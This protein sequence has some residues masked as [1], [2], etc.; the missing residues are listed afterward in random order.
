VNNAQEPK[1]AVLVLLEGGLQF[2][3]QN[4]K[5][6]AIEQW[7]QVLALEPDNRLAKEYLEAA[8]AWGIEAPGAPPLR[9]VR[10]DDPTPSK[11]VDASTRESVLSLVKAHRFEDALTVLYEAHRKAPADAAVSRSIAV[12]KQRVLSDYQRELGSL[13]QVPFVQ[14]QGEHLKRVPLSPN[15]QELVGLVDGLVTFGDILQSSQRGEL[16]STKALV[17]LLRKGV[18]Q[19]KNQSTALLTKIQTQELTIEPPP[20]MSPSSVFPQ[21]SEAVAAALTDAKQATKIAFTALLAKAVQASLAGR[22]SEAKRLLEEA[23][24]LCADEPLAR[25]QLTN[26]KLRIERAGQ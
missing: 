2:Y 8:G 1:N 17:G 15:E 6:E 18:V 16:P 20:T 5:T 11:A 24:P 25:Q 22:T 23:T 3:G 13:D 7:H 21:Q 9:V 26:L 4:R 12:M 14:L 10:N 19:V